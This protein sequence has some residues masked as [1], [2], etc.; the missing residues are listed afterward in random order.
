MKFIDGFIGVLT[1]SFAFIFS[2]L[3]FK[4]FIYI[5]GT[6]KA[7]PLLIMLLLLGSAIAILLKISKDK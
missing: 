3:M 5:A 6:I 7:V 4:L 2:V 1:I